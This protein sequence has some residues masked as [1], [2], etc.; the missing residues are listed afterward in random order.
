MA[1]HPVTMTFEQIARLVGG[2]P[3]SAY[4]HREWW[5]NSRGSHVE[6]AAWLDLRREVVAVDL[7]HRVVTFS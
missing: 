6:A 5:A 4:R 2:L 3:P 1:T 7:Q